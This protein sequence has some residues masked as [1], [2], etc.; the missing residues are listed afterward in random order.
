MIRR[1]R[2]WVLLLCSILACSSTADLTQIMVVVRSD[3]G[4]LHVQCDRQREA[5]AVGWDARQEPRL[6]TR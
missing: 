6:A 5:A 4:K 1:N 3:L 2:A